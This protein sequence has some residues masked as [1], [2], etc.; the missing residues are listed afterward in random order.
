MDPSPAS[1]PSGGRSQ[2]EAN[3]GLSGRAPLLL[4]GPGGGCARQEQSMADP[5]RAGVRQSYA[6]VVIDWSRAKIECGTWFLADFR[7]PPPLPQVGQCG[8]NTVGLAEMRH[9]L[10]SASHS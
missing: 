10:Q 9:I 1:A 3:D 2:A 5:E 8:G 6:G 7:K 4:R